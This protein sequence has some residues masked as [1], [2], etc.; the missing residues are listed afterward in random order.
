MS[1]KLYVCNLSFKT[2]STVSLTVN[3]ARPR[4]SRG[5]LGGNGS[6]RDGYVG[7]RSSRD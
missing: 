6:G 1:I 7:G 3:E 2:C 4:E 5:G